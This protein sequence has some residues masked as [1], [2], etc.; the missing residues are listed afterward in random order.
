MCVCVCVCVCVHDRALHERLVCV[1]AV[2]VF[3]RACLRDDV[4]C[5]C[6]VVACARSRASVALT[7]RVRAR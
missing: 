3:S 4:S 2:C 1:R 7:S 5:A 6:V